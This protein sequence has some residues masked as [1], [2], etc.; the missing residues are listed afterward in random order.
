MLKNLCTAGILITALLH[1]MNLE[2][3]KI[4]AGIQFNIYNCLRLIFVIASGRI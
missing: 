4:N 2:Q 1:K 3:E